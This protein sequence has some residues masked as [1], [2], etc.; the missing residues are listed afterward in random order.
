M[1]T[2]IIQTNEPIDVEFMN[3]SIQAEVGGGAQSLTDVWE[4]KLLTWT[5]SSSLENRAQMEHH[6]DMVTYHRGSRVFWFD[7]ALHGDNQERRFLGY[8]DGF[9]TDFL[10]PYRWV[11]AP[12][13]VVSVNGAV[14]TSWTLTE[15]TGLLRFNSAPSTGSQV[16]TERF[17][18]RMKAFFVVESDKLYAVTD[19]FKSFTSNQIMIREY[20]H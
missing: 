6:Q 13:L 11:Y 4:R 18:C 3:R 10:I 1:K 7:G 14:V 9:R 19:N 12:S 5:I 15:S 16:H 17:K 20:P 2:W 8:G